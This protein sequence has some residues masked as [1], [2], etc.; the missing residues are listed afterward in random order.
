[1]KTIEVLVAPDGQIRLE[2]RGFQGSTCRDASQALESTLGLRT[3]DSATTEFHATAETS[4]HVR[5][6][7]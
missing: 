1:M 2:T 6:P 7:S 5:E 3:T 4:E